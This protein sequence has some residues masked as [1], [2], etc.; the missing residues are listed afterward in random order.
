MAPLAWAPARLVKGPAAQQVAADGGEGEPGGV[1]GE[2]ARKARQGPIV[3]VGEDLF[4][5]GVAAVAFL[6]LEHGERR[7][8]EGSVVAPGGEQFVLALP[9]P[10]VEVFDPADYEAGQLPFAQGFSLA[11][12][13]RRRLLC[14][15]C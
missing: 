13:L 11:D 14:H 5:L 1:G 7:F 3:P 8:G 10:A 9:G 2:W 12:W 4:G 6:G 15:G